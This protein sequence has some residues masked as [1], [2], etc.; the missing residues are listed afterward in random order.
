[1]IQYLISNYL[2]IPNIKMAY[3]LYIISNKLFEPLILEQSQRQNLVWRHPK[4]K[5][6]GCYKWL[7]I[8]SMWTAKPDDDFICSKNGP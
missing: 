5:A 2:L 1:M 7:E 8:S 3:S 4:D 6:S